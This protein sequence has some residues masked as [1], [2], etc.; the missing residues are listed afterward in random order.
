[1]VQSDLQPILSVLT[2]VLKFA[3]FFLINHIIILEKIKAR[4]LL[5]LGFQKTFKVF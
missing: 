5:C 2:A 1:M 4:T 3:F